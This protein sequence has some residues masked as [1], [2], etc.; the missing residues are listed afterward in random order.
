MQEDD[1]DQD[2]VGRRCETHPDCYNRNDARPFSFYDVSV[3]GYCCTV[4][5]DEI[6]ALRTLREPYELQR[7]E[8]G[9]YQIIGGGRVLKSDCA[10]DPNCRQLPES[11][12]TRPGVTTLPQ[13]CEQALIDA[14]YDP[15]N[16]VYAKKLTLA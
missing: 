7:D 4:V 15:A 13:G 10:G 5:F 16:K 11:L 2:F 9:V 14:G 8:E 12:L 3:N 6:S 1:Q